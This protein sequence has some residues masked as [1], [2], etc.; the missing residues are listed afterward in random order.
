MATERFLNEA[1]VQELSRLL[2]NLMGSKIDGA[3]ADISTVSF[4][5]IAD[6]SPLPTAP[7]TENEGKFH[8]WRAATTDKWGVYAYYS[9]WKFLTDFDIDLD[10]YW[11]KA[12]LTPMTNAQ[13]LAAF[14]AG[15]TTTP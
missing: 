10:L 13:I 12:E 8:L 14:T 9:G 3:L 7:A 6:G 11:A 15:T 5:V 2:V 1:G 4:V